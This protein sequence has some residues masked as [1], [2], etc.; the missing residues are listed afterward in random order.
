ME[1]ILFVRLFGQRLVAWEDSGVL[2]FFHYRI[3]SVKQ[4]RIVLRGSHAIK[5]LMFSII[6][7]LETLPAGDQPLTKEPED[8]GYE[9]WSMN[10]GNMS[11][12]IIVHDNLTFYT[13]SFLENVFNLDAEPKPFFGE[14]KTESN[15]LQTI[16]ANGVV[17]HTF[18]RN[19]L[20]SR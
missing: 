10:Q 13:S 5:H 14:N 18:P 12:E 4:F 15:A 20:M 17:L 6:P 7:D 19:S 3:A 11:L 16:C 8:S 2:E 1:T 9:I